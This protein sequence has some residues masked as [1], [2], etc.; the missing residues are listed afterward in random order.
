MSSSAPSDARA[1]RRYPEITDE[2]LARV[3]SLIGVVLRRPGARTVASTDT[4][5]GYARAIGSRIPLYVDVAHGLRTYWGS[6]VGHPTSLYSFDDTVVAPALPG[7]QSIYAGC[8]WRWELPL[9]LGT[10]VSTT[11]VLE[12]VERKTGSFAG[13]M[14]LQTGRVEYRD[15][16]E[17]L[18]ATARPRV[19]RT[20]RDEA[21]ARGKYRDVETY[22]YSSAELDGIIDMYQNEEIRGDRPLYWEDVKPGDQL[23]GLVKGPVTTEDMGMFVGAIRQTLFFSDFL[24]HWRRHPADAYWSPDTGSPD[25]WDASLLRDDVAQEFGFA[26][27][28]DTGSQ[29][30]AW[31]ENCVSN[32]AGDFSFLR[33]LDVTLHRPCYRGDTTWVTGSVT[34]KRRVG[35]PPQ[36]RF[37]LTC[38]LTAV[39]QRGETT[40]SG[41]AVVQVVSKQT[42]T[43]PPVLRLP[44]DYDPFRGLPR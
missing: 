15:D 2:E 37:E 32:W 9:R 1:D 42:D 4:L 35:H 24:D 34:D 25:W 30:V 33:D 19:L 6:L 16:S 17:R 27:A 22:R 7:I 41:Q 8:A 28:H 18:L 10:Q 43:I 3:E 44:D 38:D 29:R 39:N 13:E 12:G 26:L 5:I 36:E 11:A 20:Q 21:R 14:V 23:P 31:I 40:A